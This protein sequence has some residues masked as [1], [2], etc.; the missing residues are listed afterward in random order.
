M[1]ICILYI[2]LVRQQVLVRRPLLHGHG[3]HILAGI[4]KDNDI[5]SNFDQ[6]LMRLSDMND[7]LL[8][9]AMRQQIPTYDILYRNLP[10]QLISTLCLSKNSAKVLTI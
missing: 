8:R 1:T 7:I 4:S 10:V 3:E 2:A 6:D 5:Q 9:F